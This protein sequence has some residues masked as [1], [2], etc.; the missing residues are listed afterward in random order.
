MDFVVILRFI[1]LV[2]SK[3]ETSTAE[4]HKSLLIKILTKVHDIYF[5]LKYSVDNVSF[6]FKFLLRLVNVL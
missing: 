4:E 2:I 1:F 6:M 3:V 5:T